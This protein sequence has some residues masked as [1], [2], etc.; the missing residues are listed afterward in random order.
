MTL[1]AEPI[2]WSEIDAREQSGALELD[3]ERVIHYRQH[4]G[5]R[6]GSD[7]SDAAGFISQSLKPK[8]IEVEEAI[9]DRVESIVASLLRTHSDRDSGQLSK[10]TEPIK[11]D[12]E[13]MIAEKSMEVGNAH[14]MSPEIAALVLRDMIREQLVRLSQ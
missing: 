7:L 6:V 10:L 1:S 5:E 3:P 12:L 9:S 2:D 14:K 4:L 11:P 8:I 13:R